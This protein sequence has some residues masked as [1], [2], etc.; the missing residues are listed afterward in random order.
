MSAIFGTLSAK[1]LG[2]LS[3][4][5][6]IAV[7]VLWLS[8]GATQ[9]KLEKCRND[10]AAVTASYLQFQEDVKAKTEFARQQDA[11]NKARV[12]ADQSRIAM[13]NDSE[14]RARI[15]AAVD[16]VRRGAAAN[17]RGGGGNQAM[18]GATEAASN[19]AR[20]SPNALMDATDGIVCSE[21]TVK[22]EGWQD[23]WREVSA[24]PR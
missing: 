9:R 1:I 16:R 8:L 17:D 19:P 2:G 5:L 13:E 7:G 20:T 22:A 10:K 21:N 6:L 15:A 12:E 11:A 3:V 18:P 4:V 23:W 14:I 24:I